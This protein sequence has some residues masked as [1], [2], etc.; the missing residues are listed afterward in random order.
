MK[1]REK[2][3]W[4]NEGTKDEEGRCSGRKSYGRR[5]EIEIAWVHVRV[6]VCVCIGGVMAGGGGGGGGGA[7]TKASLALYSLRS[8]QASALP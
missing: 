6:C 4:G 3:Q 2:G 8:L 1:E 5:N 7:V